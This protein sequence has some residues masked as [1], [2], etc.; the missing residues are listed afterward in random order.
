MLEL[1]FTWLQTHPLQ[2]VAILAGLGIVVG[3]VLIPGLHLLH[4][5]GHPTC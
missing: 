5:H 4:R 1:A 2:G 3:L